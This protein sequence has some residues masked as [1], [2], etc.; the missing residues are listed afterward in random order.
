MHSQALATSSV[1]GYR[2]DPGGRRSSLEGASVPGLPIPYGLN[3]QYRRGRLGHIDIAGAG[4]LKSRLCRVA[5]AVVQSPRTNG[6]DR[7]A[8]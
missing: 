1:K 6:L 8:V 5:P 4:W 3:W 7:G 2:P